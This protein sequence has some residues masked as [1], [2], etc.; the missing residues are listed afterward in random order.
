[1]AGFSFVYKLKRK[2]IISREVLEMCD[3]MS[4]EFNFSVN[5]STK[6]IKRLS[7]EP[8]LEH[9]TFLKNFNFENIDI[10]T[11]LNAIDNERINNLFRNIG[12]VDINSMLELLSSF[13]MNMIESNKNYE[14]YYETHS[15]L[16]IAFGIFTGLV[17]SLVLI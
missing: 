13:K 5:E 7:N 14:N 11:E 2:C 15:R 12:E 10:S 17:I 4:I 16:Y 6:I 3:L 1:M 8:S 9:L